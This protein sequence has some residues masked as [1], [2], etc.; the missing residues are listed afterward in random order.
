[1]K[2]QAE[3]VAE[4]IDTTNHIVEQTTAIQ[5][6]VK[7]TVTNAV[8]NAVKTAVNIGINILLKRWH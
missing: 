5:E 7:T 1:M 6:Q 8:T 2:D 3:K 4:A